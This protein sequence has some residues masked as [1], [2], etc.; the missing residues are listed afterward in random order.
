MTL[1][2]FY[3]DITTTDMLEKEINK[4]F[5]KKYKDVNNKYLNQ[6]FT[7]MNEV[8]HDEEMLNQCGVNPEDYE[9]RNERCDRADLYKEYALKQVE[10]T[11]IKTII[12]IH[13][14]NFNTETN[15]L[16][17]FTK[18]YDFRDY[19]E[20]YNPHDPASND[21]CPY[22]IYDNR[23]KSEDTLISFTAEVMEDEIYNIFE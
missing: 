3:H 10:K 17:L 9:D 18:S 21:F 6:V 4:W 13:K 1:I 23:L 22:S 5:N 19:V 16:K 14:I 2:K 11:N 20:H 8:Y 7:F 15:T 12:F